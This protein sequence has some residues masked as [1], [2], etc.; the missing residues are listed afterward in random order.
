V[1]M[2]FTTWCGVRVHLFD[3]IRQI[4]EDL[5]QYDKCHDSAQ[6]IV[7]AAISECL[8]WSRTACQC[9]EFFQAQKGK[10]KIVG[11]LVSLFSFDAAWDTFSRFSRTYSIDLER[12][13]FWCRNTARRYD[14]CGLPVLC[15]R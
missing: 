12:E 13:V 10:F 15:W 6:L 7:Q 8:K 2:P 14:A 1:A 4:A 3:L 11:R 9:M 5:S